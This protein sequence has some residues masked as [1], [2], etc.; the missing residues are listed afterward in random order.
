MSIVLRAE[1]INYLVFKYLLESGK[2]FLTPPIFDFLFS[3]LCLFCLFKNIDPLTTNQTQGFEH[4]AFNLF[5][6]S[7][8]EKNLKDFEEESRPGML[9]HY[10]ERGLIFNQI[11][12]HVYMVKCYYCLSQKKKY[13]GEGIKSRKKI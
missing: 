6:E 12:A 3:F 9:I 11:E 5:H 1:E 4:S 10:L 2:I 8:L 7:K 13:W